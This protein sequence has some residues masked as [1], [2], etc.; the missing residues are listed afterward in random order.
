M[1]S[2]QLLYIR[3]ADDLRL[4]GVHYI[5][6]NGNKD[7]C[8]LMIH[9]MSGNILENYFAHVLGEKLSENNFGYLYGHNR[10]Y[11]HINDLVTSKVIPGK[12]YESK[13]MGAAYERFAESLFDVDSWIKEIVTLG[14]KRIVLA[15]HSLGC[16][17]LIYYFYK[18][19]P[20]N[21]SGVIL[22]SPPE[23]EYN[24][25][26]KKLL[27]EAKENIKNGSPRKILS[28]M[29]WDWYNLSS[30]TYAEQTE[31][32]GPGDNIPIRRNPERFEQLEAL[33]VPTLCVIGEQDD[34]VIRSLDEDM[35][36]IEKKAINVKSFTKKF[37]KGASHTY[38]AVE[39]N[40]ADEILKWIKNSF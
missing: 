14:Y 4:N 28:E 31:T 32:G 11:N 21:I 12:G 24:P 23:P 26:H 5:P 17:K 3:T 33:S 10:G 13:R 19:N 22:L 8:V 20:K 2:Q 6:Q 36:L 40:L 9:G 18:R 39:E 35:D 37:I 30:Q 29:V 38:D 27:E 1:T 16:N 25:N 34:I 7:L 15:G